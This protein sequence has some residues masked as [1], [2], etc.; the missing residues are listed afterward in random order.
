[1]LHLEQTVFG[2][3]A[4]SWICASYHRCYNIGIGISMGIGFIIGQF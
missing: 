3:I 1:M 4:I 2:I